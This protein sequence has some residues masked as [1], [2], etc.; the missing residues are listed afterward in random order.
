MVEYRQVISPAEFFVY[1]VVQAALYPYGKN[2]LKG[3]FNLIYGMK[4]SSA[5]CEIGLVRKIDK[6]IVVIKSLAVTNIQQIDSIGH[7]R[8]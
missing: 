7:I 6:E 2:P 8:V 5:L 1:Y 3:F 4:V